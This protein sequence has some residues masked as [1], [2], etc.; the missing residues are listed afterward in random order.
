VIVESEACL[1]TSSIE[2]WWVA[3]KKGVFAIIAA[4]QVGKVEVLDKNA[5]ETLAAAGDG[6]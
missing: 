4:D 3:V 1:V 2:V 6:R 5:A